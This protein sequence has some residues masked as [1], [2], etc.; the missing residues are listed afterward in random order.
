MRF[1]KKILKL[2]K[3]YNINSRAKSMLCDDEE[4]AK[5]LK[6]LHGVDRWNFVDRCNAIAR[7]LI[8]LITPF[9]GTPVIVCNKRG[10]SI[11]GIIEHPSKRLYIDDNGNVKE[12]DNSVCF[13][14]YSDKSEGIALWVNTGD[15][16][17]S[18][19]YNSEDIELAMN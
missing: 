15:R 2:V 19:L 3:E 11:K 10:D 1:N 18:H 6:S 16:R 14:N 13:R 9:H 5:M 8:P 7:E 17:T 12:T 4:V